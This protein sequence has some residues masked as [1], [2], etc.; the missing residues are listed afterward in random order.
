MP[1][2][3]RSVEMLVVLHVWRPEFLLEA[4][5]IIVLGGKVEDDGAVVVEKGQRGH[6]VLH[7]VR[8]L[9]RRQIEYPVRLVVVDYCEVVLEDGFVADVWFMPFI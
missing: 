6:Q 8:L 1:C 7:Y 3:L 9:N 2:H 4:V 5:A